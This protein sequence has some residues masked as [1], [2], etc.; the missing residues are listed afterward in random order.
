MIAMPFFSPE[1]AGA[2]VAA[3]PAP[4]PAAPVAAAAEP[5]APA[6]PAGP[7]AP[8]APAAAAPA[9]PL[10]ATPAAPGPGAPPVGSV[11][12]A[13][14][15]VPEKYD[16]VLPANTLFTSSALDAA[17]AEA[18]ALQLT[19]EQAQALLEARSDSLRAQADAYEAQA[20]ADPEVG[21][22]KWDTSLTDAR[23]GRDWLFPPGSPGADLI[24]N[25][26]D[27]TGFG[28]HV[29]VIRAFAKLGRSAREDRAPGGG[30]SGEPA[31]VHETLEQRAARQFY[32]STPSGGPQ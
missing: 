30:A 17:A 28:N 15:S 20:H 3:A 29:E 18:R 13:G 1:P 9:V 23:R 19:N 25:L 10:P 24:R 4:S 21:G 26:L 7:A 12:P 27:T 32:P 14:P 2:P 6:A 8:A 11:A 31:P 22:A 5:A 16:L